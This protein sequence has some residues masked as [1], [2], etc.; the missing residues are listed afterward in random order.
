MRHKMHEDFINEMVGKRF[1]NLVVKSHVGRKEGYLCIC[2]CGNTTI[3]RSNV[4]KSGKVKGCG[5]LNAAPRP[6]KRK[7]EF[8]SVKKKFYDNYR[9]SAKRRNHVFELSVEQFFEL[10][11]LPCYYCGTEKSLKSHRQNYEY[12]HNGIDRMDNTKGYTL[13]NSVTACKICNNSKATLSLESWNKWL[14]TIENFRTL[15]KSLKE[16]QTNE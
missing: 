7:P 13:K 16:A 3:Q 1:N 9:S 2:D 11:D 12:F 8:Y 15:R 5:C 6:N 10:M 4:L 14:D